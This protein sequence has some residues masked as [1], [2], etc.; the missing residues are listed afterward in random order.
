MAVRRILVN[1]VNLPTTTHTYV[2]ISSGTGTG[3]GPKGHDEVFSTYFGT[4]GS[5]SHTAVTIHEFTTPRNITQLKYR[6]YS[7]GYAYGDDISNTVEYQLEYTTN[8]TDWI[9]ITSTT[10]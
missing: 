9:T 8:G 4:N 1:A 7:Y 10:V 2:P 5:D 6:L 3:Y